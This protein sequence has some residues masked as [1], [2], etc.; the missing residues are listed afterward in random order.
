[1]YVNILNLLREVHGIL[2]KRMKELGIYEIYLNDELKFPNI[3]I[4]LCQRLHS[5][6]IDITI[7]QKKNNA[8]KYVQ[9]IQKTLS[10]NPFIKP[11]FFTVHKLLENYNIHRPTKL[12]L[13][14]Y[15]I[16]LMILLVAY[17]KPADNLGQFFFNFI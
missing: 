8:R 17:Q 15:T 12:G 2:R 11:I 10:F 7:F 6:K 1:M 16:F 4:E 14:T 3:K 13:K 5:R 9:F